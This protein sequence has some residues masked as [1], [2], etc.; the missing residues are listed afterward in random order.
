MKGVS[1]S[2]TYHTLFET[3]VSLFE[4]FAA[5]S[6]AFPS[7]LSTIESLESIC[8]GVHGTC[9]TAKHVTKSNLT[10][11]TSRSESQTRVIGHTFLH[12]SQLAKLVSDNKV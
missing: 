6:G 9:N 5:R 1:G 7:A 4:A 2:K 8:L 11:G 3:V 10:S 12:T